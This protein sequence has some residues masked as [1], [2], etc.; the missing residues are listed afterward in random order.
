MSPYSPPPEQGIE[1]VVSE[2]P[3][4][5]LT[6]LVMPGTS[7]L[8]VL[9]RVVA[10]DPSIDVILMSA[11][12]SSTSAVEAI[13]NGAADYLSKP[14]SLPL[15]RERI[16]K[17]VD[18]ARR[19]Q[20]TA[21]IHDE[22]PEPA[23]FEGMI[24]RSPAIWEMFARIR[25]VSPYFRTVLVGGETGSGKELVARALHNLSPVRTGR[26]VVLNCSAVVETLFESE[27]FGHVRGASL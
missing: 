6:D 14:V 27:L 18:E 13:R 8:E 17:L 25:R 20:L 15:L 11:H 19:R 24:G 3:Q 7:G 5:V 23:Q 21:A 22:T 2:H 4:I 10:F 16:S 1:I 9:E 26:F 12:D